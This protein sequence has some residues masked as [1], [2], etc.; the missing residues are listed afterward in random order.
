M[1]EPKKHSRAKSLRA[2]LPSHIRIGIYNWEFIQWDPEEAE[3][4][5]LSGQC[6]PMNLEVKVRTDLPNV[7]H[8]E[9]LKHEI[10]HAC[11]F[12]VGLGDQEDEESVVERLTPV[13]LQVRRDNP[14]IFKYIDAAIA[15]A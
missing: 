5:G 9:I 1:K 12:C 13:L 3:K 10:M 6:V 15:E 4:Q 8:A 7:L 11:W 14:E 2:K